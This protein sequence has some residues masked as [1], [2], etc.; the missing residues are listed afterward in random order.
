[1]KDIT[2]EQIILAEWLA[3]PLTERSPGTRKELAAQ[4]NLS[5]KTLSIFPENEVLIFKDST[6]EYKLNYFVGSKDERPEPK[7][8]HKSK[9]KMK[10]S[11][12]FN[13]IYKIYG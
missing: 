1:M 6:H 2:P 7:F 10:S 12:F 9:I 3:S 4:L 11:D 13:N 5:D 8:E